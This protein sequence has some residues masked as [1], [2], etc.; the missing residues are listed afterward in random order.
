M[1]FVYILQSQKNGR[2]YIGSSDNPQ[3]RLAEHNSGQTTALKYLRPLEILFIQECSDRIE[4]RRLE[5]R[6]KKFKSRTVIE[7]I[8]KDQKI[9]SLTGR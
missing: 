3:R 7:K 8:I 1:Y 2:F 6:L 9:K 4:A 5:L